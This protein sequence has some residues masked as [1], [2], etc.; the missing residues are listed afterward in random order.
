MIF[1]LAEAENACA[2]TRTAAGA[3]LTLPP[4]AARDVLGAVRHAVASAEAA[5]TGERAEAVILTQPDIRR[6]VR[7]LIEAELPEVWVVSFAEL[8]PL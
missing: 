4:Q 6:F 1:S 3:F 8:V 2:V 7:K 5:R